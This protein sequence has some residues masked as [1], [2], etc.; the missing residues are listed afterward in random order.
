MEIAVSY[1]LIKITCNWILTNA[2]YQIAQ[3]QLLIMFSSRFCTNFL[4][5]NSVYKNR[6][7]H[8]RHCVAPV[9]CIQ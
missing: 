9:A 2:N 6:F 8:W 1:V 4:T 7:K 5:G 3:E